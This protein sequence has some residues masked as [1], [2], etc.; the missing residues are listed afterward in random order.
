MFSH[1]RAIDEELACSFPFSL[2]STVSQWGLIL[3]C[4]QEKY[5]MFTLLFDAL[6]NSFTLTLLWYD[7]LSANSNSFL[8]NCFCSDSKKSRNESVFDLS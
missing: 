1:F 6:R 5:L 8:P 4:I 7:A 2:L 3:E